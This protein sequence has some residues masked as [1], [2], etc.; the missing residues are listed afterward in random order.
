[1]ALN[2]LATQDMEYGEGLFSAWA[3][4]TDGGKDLKGV[5]ALCLLDRYFLLVQMCK[6]K[7]MLH[8]W[9]YARC[10]EVE[11]APTGFIDLWAREHYKSTIITFGGSIQELLRDPD[12]TIGIFSH[13]NSI[14]SDFLRQIKAELEGNEDLKAVFPDILWADPQKQAP[15]WSVDGGIIVKR[16]SN[17]KEATVE[18]SGLVDGQPTGKHYRL[19]IY[20]DVVTDKS[21]G[22]PEQILKTTNSYS[23]SQSL[24]VVGGAEWMIGTRYSYA[25]TYNWIIERG[26]LRPRIYPATENGLRDGKPVYF[27]Q[28][29]W[30]KRLLK[31]TDSDIACQYMQNP[32]SGHQAMFN[33]EDLQVYEVRPETLAVYV[34]CDPARSKKAGSANT[35]IMVWGL[36]YANN[37]YLL[38]GFNHKMD[39]QERWENFARMYMRWKMAP[40]VQQVRMGYES[41]GAQSDLD[42][43]RE[44]MRMPGKPSFDITELAW[45]RDTEGGKTDR[46]QRLV[47]DCKSHKIFLPYPTDPQSYTR[48][49]HQMLKTGYEYR[50]ARSI[51]RVDE[52]G[53]MY[54]LGDQLKMQFHYFPHGLKD[55]ID[56]SARIYDMEPA[57]PRLNEERYYEPEYA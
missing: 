38:D 26:A 40:G 11:A 22:T 23:L 48:I 54:D 31:N 50:I 37:K 36:D 49:Q 28:E 13:V 35:A 42:Y 51:K 57:A 4:I 2:P 47:P 34:L 14:A 1:M 30:N 6:R 3:R 32:L 19:R 56:A 5:R 9:I 27:A 55:A 41:F 12:I 46:V 39:L 20:D 16:N 18:A 8:P 44:Q 29:E 15:R 21:V 25:D 17:P 43:F 7:D 45:P 33:V 24:G 53:N 10:R 52:N